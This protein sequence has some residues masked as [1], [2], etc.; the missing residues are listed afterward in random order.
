MANPLNLMVSK[1]RMVWVE[2][3]IAGE[4]LNAVLTKFFDTDNKENE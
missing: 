1:K 3:Q 4:V 2:I